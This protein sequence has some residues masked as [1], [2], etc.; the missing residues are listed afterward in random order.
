MSVGL[1]VEVAD[2]CFPFLVDFDE[3]GADVPQEGCF[4]GKEGGDAG[5]SVNLFVESFEHIGGSPGATGSPVLFV[6][7]KTREV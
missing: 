5:A 7:L 2:S 6:E 1:G 4:V 3:H